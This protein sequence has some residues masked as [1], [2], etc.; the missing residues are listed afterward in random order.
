M[1]KLQRVPGQRSQMVSMN[2]AHFIM[3]I[4]NCN[5]NGQTA[6]TPKPNQDLHTQPAWKQTGNPQA[7]TQKTS[8]PLGEL[9]LMTDTMASW[10]IRDL[11]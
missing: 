4:T 6:A 8:S 1:T 5:F 7:P 3:V 9:Y 2:Q 11:T 10:H